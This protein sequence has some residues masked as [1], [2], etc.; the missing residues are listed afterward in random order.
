M[1]AVP[2]RDISLCVKCSKLCKSQTTA[3]KIGD[4][5]SRRVVAIA[6]V[7]S[8]Q[9]GLSDFS[10]RLNK[11]EVA[12][13]G[14]WVAV[15]DQRSHFYVGDAVFFGRLSNNGQFIPQQVAYIV[16]FLHI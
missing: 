13:Q 7:D 12:F 6:A 9:A 3:A 14:L 1:S 2:R 11:H 15:F 4:V 5:R 16:R 10:T 8:F